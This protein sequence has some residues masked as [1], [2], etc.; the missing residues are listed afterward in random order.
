[1][2]LHSGLVTVGLLSLGLLSYSCANGDTV[3]GTGSSTG[4]SNPT[5]TGGSSSTGTGGTHTGGV[6][7]T[8][9]GGSHTGGTTG[10]GTGGTIVTGTG[11]THTGGVS[12]TGTG[13]TIVTGTG[14][15]TT[16]G[17]GGTS[18]GATC[19]ASF[20]VSSAGF[21]TMPAKGGA[22]WS[23][24]AYTFD[25]TASVVSPV[26]PTPGFSACGDPCVLTMT[27]TVAASGTTY[28]YVGLAYNLGQ[29]QSG[30]STNTA[31][32]PTGSGLTF[33]FAESAPAGTA[34]RA[35]ITDGTN[36][37]CATVTGASP[38]SIPY[39]SFAESC[40]NTPPGTTYAK[41]PIN[42]L[43]L[44]IASGT[45]AGAFSLTITSVTE[46]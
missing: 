45:T 10:T 35:Q 28:P 13:G 14:G 12:G 1:M 5:S 30:G 39:A 40:Y 9:T 37:W 23:G 36:T 33:T 18:G 42:A 2:K 6:S 26:S 43:Q 27:G 17:T 16:A 44:Q 46:N 7:G 20:A 19:G 21:V 3:S 32:T 4:G 8:G 22:C 15:T 34:L 38:V 11:G 29:S 24:Y 31:V 25:D 41:N